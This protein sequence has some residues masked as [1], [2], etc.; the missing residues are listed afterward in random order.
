MAETLSVPGAPV[1]ADP[2]L[3]ISG[4]DVRYG[5]S[6]ILQGVDLAVGAEPLSLIGRN[7][8][9]KTTLCN[10]I[11]GLVP[12]FGGSIRFRGVEIVGRKAHEIA[13]AG[14]AY[15]PQGRRV[16][17][18]LSVDEHLRMMAKRSSD[19]WTINEGLRAVPAARRAPEERRDAALRRR[20]ADARDRPGA[21]P[22]PDAAD[23]GRAIRGPRAD[24]SSSRS[25][26]SCTT[27]RARAW[28][29]CSSSRT[30]ASRPRSPSASP[31]WS[32][33]R[34][35]ARRQRRSFLP[36][37]PPSAATSASSAQVET[38]ASPSADS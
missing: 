38:P 2:I 28:R 21:A 8:M 7:G 18:S 29:S 22:Q 4:L 14:I 1:I 10:A 12:A 5:R 25:S 31:S 26:A 32:P 15:V 27:S 6:H 30:S 20:A 36:T 13:R 17:A 16:F 34:S 11:M 35:R 19:G 23:H 3:A 24:R 9:G 37:R 33:A